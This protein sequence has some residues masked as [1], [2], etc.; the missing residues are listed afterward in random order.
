[1][2]AV[3]VLAVLLVLCIAFVYSRPVYESASR[4]ERRFDFVDALGLALGD[5]ADASAVRLG[6]ERAEI[7][8]SFDVP[9]EHEALH[10][11]AERGL[12]DDTACTLRR[13][14]GSDGRSRAFINGQPVNL[15]DLKT[16]GG[17]LVDIHGQ[18]AHQSLLDLGNQRALLDG[19]RLHSLRARERSGTGVAPRMPRAR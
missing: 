17:L 9:K 5:R 14:V 13:L 2:V 7:S 4:W 3:P 16:L 8:V 11:L 6:A 19:H 15:Q 1:M 12:D 18:H 10:W